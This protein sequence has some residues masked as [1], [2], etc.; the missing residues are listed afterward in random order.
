MVSRML[1]EI[2]GDLDQAT[3]RLAYV[4]KKT[5]DLIQK[6]GGKKNFCIILGLSFVVVIL[7][8]L[9]IYT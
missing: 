5:K 6:S 3:N 7:L 8:F 1:T 4:T 9:I 2:E